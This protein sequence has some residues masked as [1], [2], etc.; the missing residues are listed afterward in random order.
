MLN[1]CYDATPRGFSVADNVIWSSAVT[2][3][4]AGCVG[5]VL[6]LDP[7]FV[8]PTKGDFHTG[9]AVAGYGAY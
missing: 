9:A 6:T 7:G 5:K 2:T 1:D 4:G 8:D 3:G